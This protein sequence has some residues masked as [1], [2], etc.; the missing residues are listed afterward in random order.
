MRESKD[1]V[2][3]SGTLFGDEDRCRYSCRTKALGKGEPS[4]QLLSS[5]R[6]SVCLALHVLGKLLYY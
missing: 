1:P 4:E 2:V 5:E 6:G 3:Q